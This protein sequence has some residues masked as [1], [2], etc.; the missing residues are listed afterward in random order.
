MTEDPGR[1]AIG[2]LR[3]AWDQGPARREL[4]EFARERARPLYLVGGAV[5]DVL[6]GRE[7]GDWD[8]TGPGAAELAREWAG[9]SGL[10]LVT[11]HEDLPTAR[12]IVQPGSPRGF[13]DF[14]DL[15]AP[16]IEED[17]RARDFTI[18]AMAWDVR[19]ADELVDPTGGLADLRRHLVRTPALSCLQ[20]DPLRTLRAFRL[21][22]ELAFG[23]EERTAQWVR[24]CGPRVR[25]MAGE[26]VGQEMLKLFAAPHAADAIQSAHELGVLADFV[27]PVAAMAGVTQGGYHHL[28]VLGHTLLALHEVERVMNDPEDVLPRSAEAVRAW[29]ADPRRR[30]AVRLATLFHDIGKPAH[31]MTDEE[32]HIRF[33]GHEDEGARIFLHT[34]RDWALPGELRAEV[35]AMIRLHL[36]PLQLVN[37]GLRK[38]AAGEPPGEAITLAAIRRIMRDA[39]PVG[40][41]LMLLAAADRSACRG[42]ASDFEHRQQVLAM[43]DSMLRRYLDW[44]REQSHL[45]RLV[46]G[47]DLMRELD[48]PP[49]PLIGELLDAI[50]EAQ[51]DRRI[52]TPEEAMEVARGFL[53]SKEG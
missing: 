18:N 2:R 5:R 9:E 50:G 19:G 3:R 23:L 36:R 4:S 45:P 33:V 22:A 20:D 53:K 1:D 35:A 10:R 40:V 28:D 6:L 47:Y 51:E 16:T 24:E 46:T 17:L 13:L 27:P 37:E 48:L 52:S 42:P 43:L 30:A 39:E 25:E 31:R 41:G 12:V 32:G 14:A 11:L 7:V 26:R 38:L 15:R 29:V 34:A 49:G 44:A 21:A 8:L